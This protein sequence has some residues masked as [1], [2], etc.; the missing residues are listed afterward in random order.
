MS[1][2]DSTDGLTGA[3]AGLDF[4]KRKPV[5]ERTLLSSINDVKVER[6]IETPNPDGTQQE[7]SQVKVFE[8]N[9]GPRF[10]ADSQ[11]QAHAGATKKQGHAEQTVE[12]T[13]AAGRDPAEFMELGGKGDQTLFDDE[14]VSRYPDQT[15]KAGAP[16]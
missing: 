9:K 4:S 13:P 7:L 15:M 1:L 6:V 10:V 14:G 12:P 3:L 5:R 8:K 11:Q 16:E 2:T